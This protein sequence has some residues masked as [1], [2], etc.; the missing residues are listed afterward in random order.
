MQG[1]AELNELI[2]SEVLL[3]GVAREPGIDSTDGWI[4]IS[5]RGKRSTTINLFLEHKMINELLDLQR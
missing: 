4:K 2:A 5:A 1:L 3:G